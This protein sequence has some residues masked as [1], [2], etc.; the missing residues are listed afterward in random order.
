MTDF[1]K[2]PNGQ[3]IENYQPIIVPYTKLS[4]FLVKKKKKK[5]ESN[6]KKQPKDLYVLLSDSS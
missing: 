2:Q 4:L 1:F 3:C 5:F 6:W